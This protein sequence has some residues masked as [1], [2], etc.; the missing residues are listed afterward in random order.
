MNRGI[1]TLALAGAITALAAPAALGHAEVT[2]L[3]PKAG[4]TVPRSLTVVKITLSEGVLGGKLV[5]RDAGGTK[6]SKASSLVNGRRTFRAGLKTLRKGRYTAKATWLADDG[7][8][9]HK[10]WHFSVS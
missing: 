3:S 4:S 10:T 9:Q 8:K 5:V 6:V 2:K 1:R 7:D